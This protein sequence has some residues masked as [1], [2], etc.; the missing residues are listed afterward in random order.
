MGDSLVVLNGPRRVGKSVALIDAIAAMCGRAD[1]D[2]RMLVHLPCDGLKARDL[3]RAITLGRALTASV[4]LAAPR[5]R[6]WFFD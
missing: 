6:V 1:V 2:P 3:R 4:D 5:G